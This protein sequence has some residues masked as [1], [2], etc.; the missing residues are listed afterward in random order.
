MAGDFSQNQVKGASLAPLHAWHDDNGKT[1]EM[2]HGTSL[3][4]NSVK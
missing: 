1:V 2:R 4:G 3:P